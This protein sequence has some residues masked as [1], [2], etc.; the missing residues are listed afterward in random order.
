MNQTVF[1]REPA[2]RLFTT[3]PDH[4]TLT[5]ILHDFT[6]QYDF[7]TVSNL[8]Y[9]LWGKP[10]PIL[11]LGDE[12]APRRVLYVGTH[13]GME[14]ITTLLLLQF[15]QEFCEGYQQ[16]RRIFNIQIQHLY[17]ARQIFLVPLLNP[18]GVEL[19]LH[20]CSHRPA[21]ERQQLLTWNRSNPDFTHWQSNGRGV[22]LNHNY[23][24]GFEA[25]KKLEQTAGIRAGATRF[26]GDAPES[27]P[28][29]RALAQWIRSH[30][31]HLALTLH[32]QGEEIYYPATGT[33]RQSNEK[34]A[35]L[36]ARMSGYAPGQAQGMAAY[37]GLTDWISDTLHFPA[38]TLEC[39]KGENPL[40]I[41][42]CAEIYQKI[43]EILFTAPI[44]I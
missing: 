36:F 39:G 11:R 2:Y 7:L 12:N 15:V 37:G 13:H 23:N 40:P 33:C 44:L 41:S 16:H 18:D 29:T 34:I 20:G 4:P 30:S 10:I 24:A 17:R 21:Q 28:E 42:E 9:S 5:R 38:F 3:P 19:Q 35:S 26:S 6:R 27:E 8:G 14:W 43:R 1:H 25:Y 31:P 32:T 22:D